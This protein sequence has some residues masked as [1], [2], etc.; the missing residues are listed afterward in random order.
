MKPSQALH[1][2]RARFQLPDE[3]GL[4]ARGAGWSFMLQGAGLGLGYAVHVTLARWLGA[5]DYGVY[6]YVL[7]WASL[8]AIPAG[9]GF[10]ILVVR[11][12]PEYRVGERWD[13]LRG[14]LQWGS[15]RVLAVGVGVALLSMAVVVL[16]DAEG[17]GVYTR[18]LRIGLWLVPLQA[19]LS[20]IGGMYR[21]FHWIGRA[22]AIRV[23]RHA[24]MLALLFMLWASG[25]AL[26]SLHALGAVLAAALLV[27]LVMGGAL[28]RRVPVPVRQ[29]RAA[30]L[31][32]TWLRVSIPLLLVG[33]FVMVLNQT[34]ILMVGSLLGPREAGLYQAASRTAALAGLVP[35]AIAAAADPMLARLYAEGDRARLQRLA[36]VCVQWTAAAS[37]AAVVF[38]IVFGRPVLAFFGE[39]FVASHG[40][41]IILAGGQVF[42]AAF[43][44]A[45]GLLNLT[46]HQQWG[47]LIFGGSALLNV[48]LNGVGIVLWGRLGAALAT[49]TAFAVMGIALW[50]LAKKKVGVDASIVYA[51]RGAGKTPS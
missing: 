40:V 23:L 27:L 12:V 42:F 19:L 33:G 15:T 17:A 44:L 36:S 28:W 37:L 3:L 11:F 30:Y 10:P 22:Y 48:A 1:G 9:M 24:V 6:T 25:L 50:I 49:A 35:V 16:F 14:L 45:A 26:T 32:R 20:V 29:A 5:A 18:A 13:R 47:M 41:L 38:F 34:D 46:G 4:V 8:L 31:P 43:G 21:G 51:L 39:D 2:L 7:A